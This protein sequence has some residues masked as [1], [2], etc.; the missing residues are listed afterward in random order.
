MESTYDFLKHITAV[1]SIRIIYFVSVTK[2]RFPPLIIINENNPKLINPVKHLAL[3]SILA[4]FF[5]SHSI[6]PTTIQ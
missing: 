4:V 3:G 1:Y 2:P 6:P 5:I